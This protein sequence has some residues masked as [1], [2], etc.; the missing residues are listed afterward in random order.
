M[1]SFSGI[2]QWP[3]VAAATIA[4]AFDSFDKLSFHTSSNKSDF[5]TPLH[6]QFLTTRT[7]TKAIMGF[8]YLGFQAC[9]PV[10]NINF[11]V[12]DFGLG[13]N[14]VPKLFYWG[15]SENCDDFGWRKFCYLKGFFFFFLEKRW[16]SS[17]RKRKGKSL[18]VWGLRGFDHCVIGRLKIQNKI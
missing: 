15:R 6:L 16:R 4:I 11:L 2:L 13:R 5:V 14:F 12:P 3:L 7:T 1:G 10:W 17:V 9:L 8:S 18:K